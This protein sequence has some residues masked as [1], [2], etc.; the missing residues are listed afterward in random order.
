MASIGGG[1]NFTFQYERQ[2]DLDV[3]ILYLGTDASGEYGWHYYHY[4]YNVEQKDVTL[5]N[6]SLFIILSHNYD[7]FNTLYGE[8]LR[9][10]DG[11]YKPYGD[12][13]FYT[14]WGKLA[15]MTADFTMY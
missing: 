5:Q 14:E 11:T 12:Y 7:D 9:F 1:Y 3:E 15:Y 8:Q 2:N 6:V 4:I 10:Y 13:W